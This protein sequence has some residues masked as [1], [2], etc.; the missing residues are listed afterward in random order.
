M[1]EPAFD[2]GKFVKETAETHTRLVQVGM[3]IS[4]EKFYTKIRGLEAAYQKAVLDPE[5]KI[6][7]YLMAVM[8]S[9]FGMLPERY[10]EAMIQRDKLTQYEGRPDQD[11]SPRGGTL[12]A[13][14]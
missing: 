8:V 2:I 12:K 11:M 13:G 1:S 10:A 6:P 4:D 14:T 3:E 7:S 5:T 9:M